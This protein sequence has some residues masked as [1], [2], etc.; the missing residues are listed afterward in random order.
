MSNIQ[1]TFRK[2]PHSDAVEAYVLEKVAKLQRLSD[3]ITGCH[4][5]I[6]SPHA[7]HQTAHEYRARVDLTIPGAELVAS[8][9]PHAAGQSIYAAID[10]AFDASARRLKEHLERMRGDVKS[11]A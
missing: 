5:S 1:V 10:H 7:H 6:E 3:R 9:A 11:H 8:H 2:I 4:V